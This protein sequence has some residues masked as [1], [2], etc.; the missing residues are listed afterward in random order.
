MLG[1]TRMKTRNIAA[2][3]VGLLAVIA[4]TAVPM[5]AS[6]ASHAASPEGGAPTFSGALAAMDDTSTFA[7]GRDGGV[8]GAAPERSDLWVF[9]DTPRLAVH[10]GKWHLTGFIRG[11]SAGMQDFTDRRRPTSQVL[12]SRPG[13]KLS[14]NNKATQLMANPHL[15]S[16]GSGK[17]CNKIFG[18]STAESARWATGAA[19][20]PDRQ[21]V[22]IPVRRCLRANR[23]EVHRAGLGIQLLQLEEEQAHGPADRRLQ[24]EDQRC[25]DAHHA[26]VRVAGR[27]RQQR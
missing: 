20:M 24:A 23:D 4:A 1:R 27:R 12:R 19:L 14:K 11:S 17:A 8:H 9:A 15:L 3:A 2:A 21:N 7:W 6:S 5:T 13:K 26:V 22:F 25:G 16:N 18:G 10:R